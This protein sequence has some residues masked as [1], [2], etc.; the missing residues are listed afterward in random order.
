MA[1]EVKIEPKSGEK[2]G[3]FVSRLLIEFAKKGK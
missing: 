2:L 3:N 1:K